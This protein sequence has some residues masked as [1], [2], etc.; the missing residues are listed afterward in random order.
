MDKKHQVL[1][2]ADTASGDV[3]LVLDLVTSAIPV[4]GSH[5]MPKASSMLFYFL[6]GEETVPVSKL[7]YWDAGG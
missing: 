6:G 3:L 4:F 1:A 5:V 2:S 7:Q